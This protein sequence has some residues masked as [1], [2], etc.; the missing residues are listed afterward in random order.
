MEIKNSVIVTRDI[1]SKQGTFS[2]IGVS[3]EDGRFKMFNGVE[4]P[5]RDNKPF[6][7][8]IPSGQYIGIPWV[9]EKFGD[10]Y[11]IVGGTV[12]LYKGRAERYACLFHVGNYEKDVTG[13]I[14]VGSSM[15]ENMVLRSR[16]AM[17]AFRDIMG[18]NAFRLDIRWIE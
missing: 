11:A 8:C 15:G 4:K 2:S 13:C 16:I 12:S 9:S 6:E 5:W 10:V 17:D 18:E 1:T 14:G 3:S 7:S